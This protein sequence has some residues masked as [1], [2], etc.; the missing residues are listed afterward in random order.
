VAHPPEIRDLY[1]E[2]LQLGL[3]VAIA[4]GFTIEKELGAFV[5]CGDLALD[6]QVALPSRTL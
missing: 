4:D 3:E 1:I 6:D 2:L 5:E